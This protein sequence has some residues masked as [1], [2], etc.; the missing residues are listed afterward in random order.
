MYRTGQVYE[1]ALARHCSSMINL[2]LG[3]GAAAMRAL[4]SSLS[5]YS[6]S[7]KPFTRG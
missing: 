7:L 5:R 3:L 2:A 1:G 6:G 4:T